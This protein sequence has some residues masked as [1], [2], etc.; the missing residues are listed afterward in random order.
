[1]PRQPGAR[2]ER[3]WVTWLVVAV[4]LGVMALAYWGA[5]M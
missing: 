3:A 5:M 4:L 2:I 1:M